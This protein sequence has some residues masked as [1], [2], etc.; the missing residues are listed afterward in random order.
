MQ[1]SSVSQQTEGA[2]RDTRRLYYLDW[3]RV[4]AILGVFL[5]HA[6][7][8]F[9]T[10]NFEIKN[11]EQSEAITFIQAFFFPW[12]MPLFFLIAGAGTWFALRRRTASEFTR[13]RTLRLLV[14]FFVG[15]LLLG[16]IQLYL[17]W[18]HRIQTGVF[19]GTFFAFVVDR[20]WGIDP[21][22]FGAIGYHMWFLG[23]L[24][25]FSLLALPLFIW[26]KGE[27]G[28][29]AISGLARLSE[30]RGAILLF[31]I[32][33]AMVRM[34]IQPFFPEE[35]HW[36]D[37]FTFGAFFVLGYLLFTDL[38]FAQAIRRDWPILLAVGTA[39]FL[40]AMAIGLS[41]ESFSIEMAPR[42]PVEFLFWGLITACGWCWTAVM[43]FVGMRFLDRDNRGL[44]YGQEALLP[45]F[46]IHQPVIIVIAFFV[47]QWS[48]GIWPKMLVVFVGSFLISIGIVELIIKRVGTLRV[49]FGMKAGQTV[50]TPGAT[51]SQKIHA[52]SPSIRRGRA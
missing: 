29:H 43:L 12:G 10:A 32:P 36:A 33:L 20:L 5:F 28:R 17:S 39:A 26:F 7:N 2:V 51:T 27:R 6:S 1:V 19:G 42:T 22:L 44:Q 16:P 49:L 34:S 13:E 41:F 8:V 15:T 24:F 18:R 3:L 40:G 46:V 35:H 52:G 48:V 14:P 38:R 25:T 4:I 50:R 45:F 31:I 47:V 21:Q 30:Q 23:Y 37:F 9:N 11:V